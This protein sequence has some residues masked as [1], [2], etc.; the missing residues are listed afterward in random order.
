MAKP[1]TADRSRGFLWEFVRQPGTVGAVAAS[2]VFLAQEMVDG[3]D[4]R[5]IRTVVEYGPGTGSFTGQI[6]SRLEPD[7]RYLAFE[8]NPRFLQRFR[9]Q[10]PGVPIYEQSAADVARVC[11]RE[12][13][14][15]VDAIVCGLP[16]ASFSDALQAAILDATLDVLAPDG[17]FGTFAYLQGLLLPGGFRLRRHLR[18]RFASVT[19][20]RIVWRNLPPAFIYRCIPR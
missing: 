2:S 14:D 18:R 13:I 7:A 6:L 5:R 20:S 11:A 1:M 12:G 15:H 17:Q 19:T 16:W 8:I 10:Y 4:W 9:S 3:F